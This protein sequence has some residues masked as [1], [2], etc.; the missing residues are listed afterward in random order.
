LL[1]LRCALAHFFALRI[2]LKQDLS[3]TT[4][5]VAGITGMHCHNWLVFIF[6]SYLFELGIHSLLFSIS[7][8]KI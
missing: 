5:H 8:L 4:P 6:E 3:I 1:L 7:T 2:A